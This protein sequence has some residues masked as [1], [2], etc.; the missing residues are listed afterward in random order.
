MKRKDNLYIIQSDLTGMITVVV[1]SALSSDDKKRKGSGTSSSL[2]DKSRKRAD[3][4]SKSLFFLLMIIGLFNATLIHIMNS[5]CT[6]QKGI[7]S[8][9]SDYSDA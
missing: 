6:C 1:S 4:G 9:T 5:N 2:S 3:K 8:D 7:K